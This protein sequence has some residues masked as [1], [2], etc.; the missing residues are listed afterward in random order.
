MSFHPRFLAPTFFLFSKDNHV[1]PPK[2]WVDYIENLH[3]AVHEHPRVIFV[4]IVWR[5]KKLHLSGIEEIKTFDMANKI[6][7]KTTVS[8]REL[9]LINIKNKMQ[10]TCSIQVRR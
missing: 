6:L 9:S 8:Y 2:C 1:I 5:G 10:S 7:S 4:A 3:D